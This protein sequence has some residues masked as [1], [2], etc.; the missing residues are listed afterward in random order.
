MRISP[1]KAIR[2]VGYPSRPMI[3]R[4]YENRLQIVAIAAYF[5]RGA[6]GDG[7]CKTCSDYGEG[8]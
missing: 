4:G 7:S 1:Q 6:A 3:P 2:E 8:N 5:G